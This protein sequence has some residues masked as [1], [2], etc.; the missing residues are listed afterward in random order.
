MPRN[1]KPMPGEVRVFVEMIWS[2][3]QAE[4]ITALAAAN[5]VNVSEMVELILDDWAARANHALG[6]T[7]IP[8][9]LEA[10]HER[11]EAQN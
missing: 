10:L 5:H 9:V 11:K 7:D 6:N 1:P 4:T 2:E 3:E 8:L